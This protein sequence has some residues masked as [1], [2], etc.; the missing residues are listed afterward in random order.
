MRRFNF[1]RKIIYLRL[2]PTRIYAKVVGEDKTFDDEAVYT[3]RQE[4]RVYPFRH[5]RVIVRDFDG[6]SL[7]VREALS[8]LA[9]Q[10]FL[11]PAVF[12]Y[13][14]E[15]V[16]GGL[17]DIEKR[18]MHEI[19]QSGGAGKVFIITQDSGFTEDMVDDLKD[20]LARRK[21]TSR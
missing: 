18:A 14:P 17:T 21:S 20:F 15:T 2:S 3:N 10:D 9:G 19:T 4:E 1:R 5:P 11:K 13:W 7:I 8:H 16:E 12:V 6:A